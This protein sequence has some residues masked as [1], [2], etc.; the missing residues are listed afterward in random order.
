M[1]KVVFIGD[2]HNA[3]KSILE[4]YNRFKK[5]YGDIG[6]PFALLLEIDYDKNP[7]Q[8][9][10]QS[11]DIITVNKNGSNDKSFLKQLVS[12]ASFCYG[13]DSSKPTYSLE[14]QNEQYSNIANLVSKIQ[15]SHHMDVL[16]I[17]GAAHLERNDSYPTWEPH[18]EKLNG[19]LEKVYC[20]SMFDDGKE[21]DYDSD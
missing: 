20:Y 2:V 13:F 8:F 5:R 3:D 19:S 7:D 12:K 17:V 4:N 11:V 14:R 1:C 10:I 6:T 21:L 15:K 16:V 18:H 9:A